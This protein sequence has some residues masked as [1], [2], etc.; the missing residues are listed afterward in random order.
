[1]DD[2]E[3]ENEDGAGE[4]VRSTRGVGERLVVRL[5][6]LDN[7]ARVRRSRGDGDGSYRVAVSD[8]SSLDIGLGDRV[9]IG[10]CTA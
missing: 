8:A 10:V 9:G 6:C 7:L 1:M 3:A 4:L 2:G 5:T